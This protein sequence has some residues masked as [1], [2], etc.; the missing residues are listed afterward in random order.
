MISNVVG[1]ETLDLIVAAWAADTATGRV[2]LFDGDSLLGAYGLASQLATSQIRGDRTLFNL[3]A[4][5]AVGD[6]DGDLLD[7]F[8][9]TALRFPSDLNHLGTAYVLSLQDSL[10]SVVD[11]D[12][13]PVES[14]VVGTGGLRQAEVG[15][16]NGDGLDD[17]LLGA[18]SFK[19]PS[20]VGNLT[21]S[22]HLL[23]SPPMPLGGLV[24]GLDEGPLSAAQPSG[25][26]TGLLTSVAGAIAA[27][28]LALGG[29]AWYA[30]RR[31]ARA[32]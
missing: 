22:A 21:G 30:R 20:G 15:D 18:G 2:Y 31:W 32:L 24:V 19:S 12:K 1:D 7:D 28:T 8:I 16:F 27:G 26:N 6:V 29:A 3:G 14:Q 25:S 10:P 23:L 13:A 11:I 17:L 4:G 5:L 9:V